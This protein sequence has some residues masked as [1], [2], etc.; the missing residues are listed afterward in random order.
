MKRSLNLTRD[1]IGSST[2]LL[3]H[4]S[5][6][7]LKSRPQISTNCSQN[8]IPLCLN[9]LD[10]SVTKRMFTSP[11]NNPAKP[12]LPHPKPT[13][14]N[15]FLKR[16]LDLFLDLAGTQQLFVFAAS[17]FVSPKACFSPNLLGVFTPKP[18]VAGKVLLTA[19]RVRVAGDVEDGL[20]RRHPVVRGDTD[21]DGESSGGTCRPEIV[22]G[23]GPKI[24]YVDA[25][26]I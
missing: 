5:S 12:G 14:C 15:E 1:N 3:F 25:G 19:V 16:I 7:T 4:H 8:G 20:D 17:M 21:G 6:S 10:N 11:L 22:I 9:R 13:I 2:I 24:G 26:G 23:G 18:T